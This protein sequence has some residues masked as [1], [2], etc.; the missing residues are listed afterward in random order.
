MSLS[1]QLEQMRMRMNEL[2]KQESNLV[3]TLDDALRATDQQLLQDVRRLSA[4]HEARRSSILGELQAL[5]TRLNGFPSQAQQLPP[6]SA[7]PPGL[8]AAPADGRRYLDAP[9]WRQRSAEIQTA[10]QNMGTRGHDPTH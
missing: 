2:A 3:S 1:E 5:A 6:A 4:E 9:D 10:L 7:F 8:F